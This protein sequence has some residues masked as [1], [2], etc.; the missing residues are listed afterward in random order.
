MSRESW[1]RTQ[2]RIQ[3]FLHYI[4]TNWQSSFSKLKTWNINLPGYKSQNDKAALSVE[5]SQG[6]N[7]VLK[8]WYSAKRVL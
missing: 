7:D 8:V 4:T 5:M 1:V 3:F 6:V 2:T